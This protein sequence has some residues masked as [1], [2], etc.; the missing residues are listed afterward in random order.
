[1]PKLSEALLL[2]NC[3]GFTDILLEEPA[4]EKEMDRLNMWGA[5][6]EAIAEEFLQADMPL[7]ALALSLNIRDL[8]VPPK[9]P[10]REKEDI[11]Q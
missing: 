1:M 11:A 6:V 9:L 10:S 3:P 7:L 5:N 8:V 4:R 2:R